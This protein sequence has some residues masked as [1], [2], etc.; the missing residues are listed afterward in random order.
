MLIL[1]FLVKRIAQGLLIVFPS[2]RLSSSRLLR[3]VP[4]RSGAPESS[5]AMGAA[6]RRRE[7]GDQDGATRSDHRAVRAATCVAC[8]KVISGSHICAPRSGMVANRRAVCRS[9]QVRYGGGDR[10]HS[11]NACHSR[12]SWVAWRLLFA[13][14]ISFPIGNCRRAAPA[15]VAECAGLRR[16]VAVR[17]DFR[18]SGW[19]SS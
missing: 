16:A 5:A 10:P 15:R 12:F 19:R 7:G 17:V 3:V 9:D 13:L 11:R 2:P 1:E 14:L 6:R 4:R 18:T 8:C